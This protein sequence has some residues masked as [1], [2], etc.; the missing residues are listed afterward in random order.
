M[1]AA[2]ASR[3]GDLL[4]DPFAERSA[5]LHRVSLQVLGGPIRFESNSPRLLRLVLQAFGGLPPHRLGRRVVPLRVRLELRPFRHRQSA[6]APPPVQLFSGPGFVGG[7]IDA[8]NL[9]I[10]SPRERMAMVLV[11]R[12]MLRFPY[13]VRYELIEFAVYVL[14]ARARRLVPLHAAMVALDGRAL[15]VMGDSGSGKSTLA[16]HCALAG[17]EFLSEDS[18][19][20]APASLRAT[21]LASFLHLQRQGLR[22]LQPSERRRWVGRAQTIRRRSGAEKLE[23]NPRCNGWRLAPSPPQIVA[24]V[25]LSKARR[26]P[27]LSRLP[28]RSQAARLAAL[29]PYAAQQPGWRHFRRR[30]ARV[31]A[32]ELRR[33]GHPRQAVEALRALLD[34]PT[35]RAMHT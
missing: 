34:R 30:L 25:L 23:I 16:L 4:G 5:H 20:V 2:R 7:A 12:D 29:Q 17:L 28:R 35:Q 21:G 27:L 14:A 10:V 13:H 9:A 1:Y 15:L 8:S 32:F 33:R 18:V 3:A 19:F 26:G 24:L 11:S 31:N 22:L 6:D